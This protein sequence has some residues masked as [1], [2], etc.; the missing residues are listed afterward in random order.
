MLGIGGF[1]V[2]FGRE[3]LETFAAVGLKSLQH[4]VE[5]G[6][7][8]GHRGRGLEPGRGDIKGGRGLG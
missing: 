7:P 8:S 5:Q 3:G 1:R 4:G 2:G 6:N